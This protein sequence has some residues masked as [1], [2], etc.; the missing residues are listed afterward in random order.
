MRT[1]VH[2]AATRRA[3][4]HSIADSRQTTFSFSFS[5]RSLVRCYVTANKI[6]IILISKTR[7]NIKNIPRKLLSVND[8]LYYFPIFQYISPPTRFLKIASHSSKIRSTIFLIIEAN[9]ARKLQRR[10]SPRR[11]E[12][13]GRGKKYYIRS[14]IRRN[15][16]R[17][18]LVHV[19]FFYH[20][21]V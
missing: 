5:S 3:V 10:S 11:D 16:S 13:E 17:S 15:F 9:I 21:T 4:L 18:S 2:K 12:G 19:I 1:Y 7:K 6:I 14:F 8:T 20:G